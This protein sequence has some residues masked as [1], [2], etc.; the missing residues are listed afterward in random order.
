MRKSMKLTAA[1]LLSLALLFGSIPSAVYAAEVSAQTQ[2]G[3]D[4]MTEKEVDVSDSI[5]QTGGF[6]SE[7]DISAVHSGT[8]G[9]KNAAGAM[10][11]ATDKAAVMNLL[12]QAAI[13]WDG[14]A[15]TVTAQMGGIVCT[16]EDLRSIYPQFVNENPA[17]GGFAMI[18]ALRDMD[19]IARSRLFQGVPD[20]FQ[21]RV[22]GGARVL[23]LADGGGDI[24]IRTESGH[25]ER[26]ADENGQQFFH[27]RTP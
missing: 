10:A 5:L 21:R 3:N 13:S 25:G 7:E 1:F 17:A 14:T 23:F 16:T 19:D 15:T 27:V 6:V 4:T 18:V 26:Q 22:F 24:P 20:G 8:A 9:K 12:Y 2:L 11:A